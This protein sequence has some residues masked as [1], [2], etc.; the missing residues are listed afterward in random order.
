M[1]S[2][3]ILNR[4][5]WAIAIFTIM[6]VLELI[7]PQ[8][9]QGQRRK[10]RWTNNL[11]LVLFNILLVR[12]VFPFG[13]MGVA[14]YVQTK[15]WGL[16]PLLGLDF[17]L[18]NL[19]GLILLDFFIYWQHRIFHRIPFFWRLHRVHH[20]DTVI[21]VSTALR[22]HSL[23]IVLSMFFKALLIVS[24]GF[25][26]ITV[27]IFEIILNGMAMFNHANIRL[28]KILDSAIKFILVTPNMHRI[29]HSIY[30]KE[31]HSNYGFNISI[32]DRVFNSYRALPESLDYRKME[33]GLKYFREDRYNHLIGMFI[34]FLKSK[35]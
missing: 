25:L 5:Y 8:N 26:P 4:G 31:H 18:F 14:I 9:E 11:L 20:T 7:I 34:Q 21:D 19:L 3:E 15:G 2:F 16:L 23:E 17:G 32:W 24:F 10:F 29:H 6:F 28:P 33:I 13:A 22:F 12:L 35:K 30:P 27:L 1:E